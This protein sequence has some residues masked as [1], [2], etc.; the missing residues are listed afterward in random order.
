MPTVLSCDG[1][2]QVQ[3]VS[4]DSKPVKNK[5]QKVGNVKVNYGKW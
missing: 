2:E 3:T 5:T 1:S 4:K